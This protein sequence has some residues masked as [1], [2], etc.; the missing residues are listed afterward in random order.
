MTEPSPSAP[1]IDAVLAALDRL[2][3]DL[4][5]R[6]EEAE[7]RAAASDQRA[8]LERQ[9]REA[10]AKA[11]RSAEARAE[12]AEQGARDAIHRAEAAET[13]AREG[14][15]RLR[16][17]LLDAI[18]EGVAASQAAAAVATQAAARPDRRSAERPGEPYHS[19][20][21]REPP[22]FAQPMAAGMPG[23]P[24]PAPRGWEKGAGYDWIEDDPEPPWWRRVFGRGRRQ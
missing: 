17:D 2:A 14:V 6:T 21:D 12:L 1:A 10:E 18:R 7:S 11:R 3:G 19:V 16:R 23:P 24:Q 15:E 20:Q 5:R 8:T 13:A 22:R 4:R 9:A